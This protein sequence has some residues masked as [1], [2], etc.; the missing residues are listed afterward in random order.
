MRRSRR[1]AGRSPRAPSSRRR[2]GPSR[3]RWR[4][5]GEQ[6]GL[7]RR[8]ARLTRGQVV[9]AALLESAA[10]TIAGLL[11]GTVAAAGTFFSVLAVTSAVTGH[12]TLELA[13]GPMALIAAIALLVTSV[14]SLFGFNAP[15]ARICAPKSSISGTR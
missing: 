9:R 3:G 12:S 7:N 11:L 5:T 6:V 2:I 15:G 1:T 13:W 8:H 10:V 14:T 4:L